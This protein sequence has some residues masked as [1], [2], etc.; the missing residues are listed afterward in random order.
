MLCIPAGAIL[1]LSSLVPGQKALKE[2]A[3]AG[4]DCQVFASGQLI[5]VSETPIPDK[6][7]M[8]NNLLEC[9]KTKKSMDINRFYFKARNVFVARSSVVDFAFRIHI[10]LA[11]G[12]GS[13]FIQ[14]PGQGNKKMR[15][16]QQ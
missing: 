8:L 3:A 12:S 4:P 5:D 1:V 7:R 15:F 2:A 14:L 10:H 6:K 11:L 16:Q 9:I 13:L